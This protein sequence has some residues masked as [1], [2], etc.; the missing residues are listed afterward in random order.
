MTHITLPEMKPEP[1]PQH[2]F[3]RLTR[4]PAYGWVSVTMM[5]CSA[6]LMAADLLDPGAVTWLTAMVIRD[7][8]LL[9]LFTILATETWTALQAEPKRLQTRLRLALALPAILAT[10]QLLVPTALSYLGADLPR[11]GSITDLISRHAPMWFMPTSMAVSAVATTLV[12]LC[13]WVTIAN[14][15]QQQTVADLVNM[16]RTEITEER[17][18]LRRLGPEHMGKARYAG[19]FL[20]TIDEAAN[21]LQICRTCLQKAITRWSNY[22]HQPC[23]L[24]GM[25]RS[26]EELLQIPESALVFPTPPTVQQLLDAVEERVAKS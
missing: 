8:T 13:I 20:D 7:T 22:C 23:H 18:R 26:I 9:C 12:S 21:A 2:W 24:P 6:S 1:Y 4:H 17:D 3:R 25:G 5:A 19:Q 14:R 16:T 15:K 11:A 10:G